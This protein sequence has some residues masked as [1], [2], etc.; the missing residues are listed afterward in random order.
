MIKNFCNSVIRKNFDYSIQ[1]W[2][3][4]IQILDFVANSIKF[5]FW[6]QWKLCSMFAV[7][8]EKFIC[9]TK[10]SEESIEVENKNS[11]YFIPLNKS[12]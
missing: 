5:V 3:E 2:E 4:K 10:I 9:D 7:K 6:S 12:F 11:L 1:T 8:F